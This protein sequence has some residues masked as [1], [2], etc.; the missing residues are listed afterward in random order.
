MLELNR[1]LDFAGFEAFNADR[2]PHRSAVYN[3]PDGLKIWEK[4]A[5]IHAGYLLSDAAFTLGQT[6]S[7]NSST[8]YRFF[9]ADCAYF[10]HI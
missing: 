7:F 9:A 10:G 2:D 6:A 1:F 4:P 5:R 3:G 8:G